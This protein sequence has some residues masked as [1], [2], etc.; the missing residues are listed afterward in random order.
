MVDGL[1]FETSSINARISGNDISDD[2]S[3]TLSEG[4]TDL[5]KRS[6]IEPSCNNTQRNAL[7]NLYAECVK[8]ADAGAD[9]ALKGPEKRYNH[10]SST[11]GLQKS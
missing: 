1:E 2:I 3:E 6:I 7:N 8:L 10:F 9:G 5:E 4:E 11:V